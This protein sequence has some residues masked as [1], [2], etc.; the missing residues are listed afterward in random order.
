MR[1]LRTAVASLALLLSSCAG[2]QQRH[3]EIFV[4]Q[5]PVP[6]RVVHEAKEFRIPQESFEIARRIYSDIGV[7]LEFSEH[8]QDAPIT[9]R[10]VE[11]RMIYDLGS[12]LLTANGYADCDSGTVYIIDP[13]LANEEMIKEYGVG[14]E[15]GVNPKM[16]GQRYERSPL[17]LAGTVVHEIGHI[18]G[19]EH[20]DTAGDNLMFPLSIP[21]RHNFTEEQ[22]DILREYFHPQNMKG[23]R[24]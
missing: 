22:K 14:F 1:R 18:A 3:S 10:E 9:L 23:G 6:I 15:P 7:Q 17:E 19:L 24:R 5:K 16:P 13:N 11:P 8:S 12:D 21:S 2:L 20:A 4:R